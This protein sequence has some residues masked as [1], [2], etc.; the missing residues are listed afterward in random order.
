QDC[1]LGQACMQGFCGGPP[2]T[3][4]STGPSTV[5]SSTGATPSCGNAVVEPEAG[6]EC[7][8]GTGLDT[9]EC[10]ADCTMARCGDGYVN[11]EAGE[12]CDDANDSSL[13]PCT[14]DCRQTLFFDD[15]EQDPIGGM[16]WTTEIPTFDFEGMPFMLDA[17][18]QWGVPEPGVWHSGPY[19]ESSGTARLMTRPIMFPP[20]PGPGFQYELRF[21]HRLRFDGNSMDV[22]GSVCPGALNGDGGVVMIVEEAG[23]QRPV[24]PPMGHPD[25]LDNAGG[26]VVEPTNPL[27]DPMMDHPAYTGIGP[28]ALVDVSLVLPEV[29]GKTVRLVFEVGYDCAN[30]WESSPPMGAGWTIDDVVVAAFP[31]GG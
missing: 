30:C 11:V 24:G 9:P 10:N 7:D 25:L 21:R 29:A 5:D 4:S 23:M 1:G 8:P 6:E 13:D 20:D 19:S 16:N 12:A 14:A 18:W 26:C 22:V 15:L 31:G 28:P 17:G 2:A 3:G 27:Y